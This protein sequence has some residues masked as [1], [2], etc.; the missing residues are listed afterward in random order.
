[1]NHHVYYSETFYLNE[2]FRLNLMNLTKIAST[3]YLFRRI[4]PFMYYMK[5]KLNPKFVF[6]PTHIT[7][8]TDLNVCRYDKFCIPN[9][10]FYHFIVY[11]NTYLCNIPTCDKFKVTYLYYN[12][13]S[14]RST[15]KIQQSQVF[16]FIVE[17]TVVVKHKQVIHVSEVDKNL[18]KKIDI[19]LK[20]NLIKLKAILRKCLSG[21]K[22][23]FIGR[24][25]TKL[26]ALKPSII[27]LI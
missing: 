24:E 7:T 5:Y 26:Y 21:N 9:L 3:V 20:P 22:L 16:Y 18:E 17:V 25:T 8:Y 6:L 27:Q 23:F 13:S 15:Y 10:Y 19:V 11:R 2:C 14:I 12:K 4:H 1:M